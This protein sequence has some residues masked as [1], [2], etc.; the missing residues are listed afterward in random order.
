MD[1]VYFSSCTELNKNHYEYS[2]S[3]FFVVTGNLLLLVLMKEKSGKFAF[4]TSNG[5]NQ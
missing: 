4:N 1:S 3:E 2:N 5:T